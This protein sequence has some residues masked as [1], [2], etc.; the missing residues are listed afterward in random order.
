M[1]KLARYFFLPTGILLGA[2]CLLA[3]CMAAPQSASSS[4]AASAVPATSA[5]PAPLS[6][7]VNPKQEDSPMIPFTAEEILLTEFSDGMQNPR[8]VLIDSPESLQAF[9]EENRTAYG[10][11]GRTPGES[12]FLTAT[13]NLD[14]AFFANDSLVL[15]L[16]QEGSGG[17]SH[18]F[19]ALQSGANKLQLTLR[20]TQ[21]SGMA[22][23]FIDARCHLLFLEGTFPGREQ[24]VEILIQEA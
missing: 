19:P 15:V 23:T 24:E 13:Q 9:Y 2:L 8:G 17:V 18:E 7:S 5:A 20:R 4:L 1:Q 16:V 14:A 22:A 21:P 12:A 6:S 11:D 3:G 10:L